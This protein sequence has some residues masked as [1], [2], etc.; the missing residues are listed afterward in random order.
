M[1]PNTTLYTAMRFD[2]L[3][4][5][6]YVF[7]SGWVYPESYVPYCMVRLI[8]KGEA[9][10]T[11]N[12]KEFHVKENQVVY[13]PE[14]CTLY[15]ET[16][17]RS[18]EFISI[19]FR[20][21]AQLDSGDF[22][23]DYYRVKQVTNTNDDKEIEAYFNQVWQS[24]LSNNPWKLFSIRGNLELIIAWLVEK[25]AKKTKDVSHIKNSDLSLANMLKRE[26][27]T[28]SR[29]QDPRVTAL[30]DY[31]INHI[32]E[33]FTASK[34]SEMAQLSE[35][36]MR[37][38]FTKYTG[39]SPLEFIQDLRLVIAARRMLV[40]NERISQIAYSVGFS[41]PNYFSRVFRDKFGVSPQVYR[42]N[43]D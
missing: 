21:T 17:S 27:M 22:L 23:A 9:L 33:D 15:C 41:D 32:E 1:M 10:F 28:I 5:D 43:A 3:Y 16:A 38:L 29:T 12:G 11:I 30:V 8:Q 35:S 2:F 20:L 42:K 4:V 36:S 19:R 13:I 25:A 7:Q 26:Q 24:A 14:G 34:L 18:F 40:T 39:K 37:R 31:I 6:R